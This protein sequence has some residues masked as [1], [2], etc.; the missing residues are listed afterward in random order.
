MK[1]PSTVFE[2]ES[3]VSNTVDHV[4]KAAPNS[5]LNASQ[6]N[7]KSPTEQQSAAQRPFGKLIRRNTLKSSIDLPFSSN[8]GKLKQ[9]IRRATLTKNNY[10]TDMKVQE[11]QSN[12]Y[13]SPLIRRAPLKHTSA[14]FV[15]RKQPKVKLI[16]NPIKSA[17]LHSLFHCQTQSKDSNCSRTSSR[18]Q[19][20]TGSNS[21]DVSSED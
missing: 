6:E 4:A 18:N 3:C 13:G 11:K 9:I 14:S 15:K 10:S 12:T 8:Q 19:V 1:V 16:S 2:L 20:D 21:L 7:R 5:P 17:T